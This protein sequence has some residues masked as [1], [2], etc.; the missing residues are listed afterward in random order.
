M[1]D[2]FIHRAFHLVLGSWADGVLPT[3]GHEDHRER[4]ER[5]AC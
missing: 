3:G 5:R 2:S 1:I 4:S